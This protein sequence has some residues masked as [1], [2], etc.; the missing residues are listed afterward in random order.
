M[1]SKR[2]KG[3]TCAYCAVAGISDTGDHVLSREFVAVEHRGEIP[4][5][6]ACG[7]CNTK[8]S[9]LE[10]YCTAV[11]PFGGRH[12]FASENLTANVPKRLARHPKLHRSLSVGQS[13]VW[14]RESSGL[15]VNTMT[16]PVDG[17]R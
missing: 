5:V 16:V 2:F 13:R 3:K 15:L 12:A 10:T 7:P 8:K 6:P 1:S 11:L 14:S 4:K 9:A 17:E